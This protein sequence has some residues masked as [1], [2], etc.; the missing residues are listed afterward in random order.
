V[1]GCLNRHLAGKLALTPAALAASFLYL[2]RRGFNGLWR[3]NLLGRMNVPWGGERTTPLPSLGQLAAFSGALK[4]ATLRC[5]D[6]EAVLAEVRFGDVVYADPPYAGAFTGYAGRF[7][8]GDQRRL[9]D[10]LRA[11]WERGA[12]IFT[13]N[14]DHPL[15]REL[16]DGHP[17]R[18]EPLGAHY[19]IGG[20]RERRASA[21]ELLIT[22]GASS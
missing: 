13:T 7:D 20:R 2:N 22:A 4:G 15:V 14:A 19:A 6:F 3:T 17:F 18:R 12:T 10:A 9:R 5:C 8:T 11:A 21:R 1:K 16:Y